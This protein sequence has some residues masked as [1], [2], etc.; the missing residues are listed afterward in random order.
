MDRGMTIDQLA[1]AVGRSRSAV[2]DWESDRRLPL[3]SSWKQIRAVLGRIPGG[4]P[5]NLG[6]SVLDFRERSGLTQVELAK[7][8]RVSKST[9]ANLEHGRKLPKR[10]TLRKLCALVGEL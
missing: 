9:I 6:K 1:K 2:I 3:A 8:L 10:T 4:L 7:Q 5:H